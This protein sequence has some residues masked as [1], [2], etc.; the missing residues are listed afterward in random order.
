MLSEL[1]I[2]E[3]FL[4]DCGWLVAGWEKS[5]TGIWTA[6]HNHSYWTTHAAN[7]TLGITGS[8]IVISAGLSESHPYE[9]REFRCSLGD[10]KCLKKLEEIL[11]EL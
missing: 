11:R 6:V 3:D 1:K 9:I 8:D 7:P 2:I 10:P 4:G 5:P